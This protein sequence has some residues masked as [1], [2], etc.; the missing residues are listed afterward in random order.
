MTSKSTISKLLNE[1]VIEFNEFISTLDE[2]QFELN[3]DKKW[4]AGQDLM[5]LIKVLKIVNLAFSLPKIGLQ[6]MYGNNKKEQ[7]SVEELQTLYKNALKGG[8]KAP[9]IYIPKPV[10]FI[11]KNALIEK[12]RLLNDAFIEKL[13]N[14]NDIVLDKY[15]LPH[16]ILGKITL[17]ELAIFTSFHTV[18]HFELLKSKI[19]HQ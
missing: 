1:S 3:P 9:S 14:Q 18:H 2:K 19:I 10:F 8:A 5:H 7:R 13:N 12:H 16:P 4:S 15:R 6:I 17:R 11:E